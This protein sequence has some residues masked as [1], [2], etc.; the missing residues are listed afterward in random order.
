MMESC[1]VCFKVRKLPND[2]WEYLAPELLP[3]WSNAPEQ[4]LGRLRDDPPDAEATARYTFFMRASCAVISPNLVSTPKT[5]LF[6]GS[7]AAGSTSKQHG[8]KS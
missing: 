3:G 6:T 4:L 2:E 7:T 8:A 1:G 5:Q